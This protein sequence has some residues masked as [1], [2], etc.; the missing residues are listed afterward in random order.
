MRNTPF[1]STALIL[2][3]ALSACS[4]LPGLNI[5]TGGASGIPATSVTRE[6]DTEVYQL[7]TQVGAIRAVRVVSL[8]PQSILKESLSSSPVASNQT[9][10]LTPFAASQPSEDYRIGPGDVLGITVWDHPELTNPAGEFRDAVSGGRLVAA[11]GSVFYPYAGTFKAAGKTA[12]E[13][14]TFL[15]SELA[16]VIS[17][18]Q[19]DV[20]IAAYR[21]KRIQVTG[22]VAQP[23]QIFL[24]DSPRGV[25]EAINER[26]GP[27]QNASRRLVFLRR[28][29]SRYELDLASLFSGETSGANP[30]LLPGD[31][32]YVPD[33]S[34][35]QVFVLGQVTL[36][37]PVFLGEQKTTLTQVLA[38]AKGLDRIGGNDAGILVFRR[39]QADGVASVFRVDLSSSMGLLLAGEFAMQPRD[40]VY[41][42]ATAFSK[43]NSVI[44]QFLPTI[45][46]I[47]QVNA[48][49]RN[50]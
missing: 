11:D 28:G 25:V 6:A 43:Y 22:A 27:S 17:K 9:N 15:A 13:L 32:V 29:D 42:S 14:R 31:Q 44:N 34:E 1:F 5:S 19:V 10:A 48:L 26:G 18:P 21:S 38:S 41:V 23:G 2:C 49:V 7:P 30:L 35:D 45:S 12:A 37:G 8:T 46:A 33:R 39:P 3:G 40:V 24:D 4:I 16:R 47:F 50:R 20:R 36:E